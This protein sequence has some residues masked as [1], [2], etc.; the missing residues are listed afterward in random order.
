LK[1]DDDYDDDDDERGR[2][3]SW[4]NISNVVLRNLLGE[5]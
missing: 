5:R 1:E 3:C 4:L 2:V